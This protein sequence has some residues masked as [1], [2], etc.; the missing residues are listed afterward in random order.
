MSKFSEYIKTQKMYEDLGEKLRK[1]KDDFEKTIPL[2]SLRKRYWYLN[3]TNSIRDS[4]WNGSYIDLDRY[5]SGNVFESNEQAEKERLKRELITKIGL[6][7]KECY[8]DWQPD[9]RDKEEEKYT[10]ESNGEYLFVDKVTY[11]TFSQ[12]GY[13]KYEKECK[14]A[15]E[16]FE[17]ELYNWLNY[18]ER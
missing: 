3:D 9:W 15:L 14:K 10:I 18:E 12:F 8:G 7:R 2:Q 5:N 1:A 17:I 4:K 6:F 11:D 13:F 16:L